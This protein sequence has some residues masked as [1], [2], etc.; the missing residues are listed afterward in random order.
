MKTNVANLKLQRR[1]IL[2]SSTEQEVRGNA[3]SQRAQF[4][5]IFASNQSDIFLFF[6]SDRYI[7]DLL[8]IHPQSVIPTGSAWLWF[9]IHKQRHRIARIVN[10]DIA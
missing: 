5:G 9:S 10:K 7:I 1:T 8:A 3:F 2:A 4:D 6:S